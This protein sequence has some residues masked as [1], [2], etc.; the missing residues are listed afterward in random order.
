MEPISAR[1][2]EIVRGRAQ[3]QLD[4]AN[5]PQNDV[6]LKKW[7]AQAEGRRACPPIRLLY[8]NFCHEVITPRLQCEGDQARQIESSLL[9]TLVGRELFDDDTPIA[10]T[11]DMEWHT[12]VQPF[13]ITGAITRASGPNAQGIHIDPVITDLAGEIDKLRGGSFGVDR[14]ATESRRAFIEDIF[15]DILPVRMVMNSLWGSITGPLVYLMGMEAYYIAMYDCPEAVHEAMEMETRLYEQYY[16]FLEEEKLLLPTNDL[17]PLHQES[18]AFT[19]ELPG[20]AVTRTTECWG[21]LESQ[22]STAV[23]ADTFGEFVF[24]Y[25]QRLVDRFGLLSY[26]CCERVDAI[27]PDYLSTWSNLRKLSVSPFNDE[28]LIGEYLR[29]TRVVYYSKPRAEFV[30]CDGPMNDD[31]INTYFKGV[32]EAASGCL[33]EIAQREVGTIFGDFERGRHYVRLAR[34]AVDAYWRP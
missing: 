23:S 20:D 3:L 10:P 12:H 26:G 6:I 33:F 16:D 8:S 15:G 18:F 17:T 1:D 5:A 31:A 28:P 32:C 19:D 21:F 13:G 4:Y 22:E 34:E 29:G 9:A 25:Q 7:R 24:P 30:T 14:A 2:R 11:F 27:W